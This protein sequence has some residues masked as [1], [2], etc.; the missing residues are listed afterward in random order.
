MIHRTTTIAMT[1]L[2]LSLAILVP[3]SAAGPQKASKDDAAELKAA[4]DERIKVLTQ[5]VEGLTAQCRTGSADLGQVFAA[6][7]DLCNAML[8]STDDPEKRVVFLSTQLDKMGE[9][10]KTTQALL[11][12]GAAPATDLLRAKSLN[13]DIKIKLLRERSRQRMPTLKQTGNHP[14]NGGLTVDKL[15]TIRDDGTPVGTWGVDIVPVR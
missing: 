10:V 13:L 12:A 11:N 9:M 3:A 8:E 2:L 5:L 4:Q 14:L 15:G 6:E 1:G 7:T